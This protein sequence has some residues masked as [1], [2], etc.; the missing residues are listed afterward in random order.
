ML[1]GCIW[2]RHRRRL[3]DRSK[4][5]QVTELRTVP[6]QRMYP[7]DDPPVGMQAVMAMCPVCREHITVDWVSWEIGG[8]I[9]DAAYWEHAKT[10]QARLADECQA[11]ETMHHGGKPCS[12]PQST[13]IHPST[14]ENA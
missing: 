4:E 5:K 8:F 2:R 3:V 9:E 14:R 6:S 7:V 11:R 12:A 10:V 13:S 1:M